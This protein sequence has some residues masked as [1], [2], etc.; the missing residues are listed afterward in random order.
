MSRLKCPESW[1]K[2]TWSMSYAHKNPDLVWFD[3]F[4][5]EQKSTLASTWEEETMIYV[6]WCDEWST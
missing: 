2:A 5:T 1:S 4:D 6:W 3:F